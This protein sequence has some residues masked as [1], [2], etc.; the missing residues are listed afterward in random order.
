[1]GTCPSGKWGDCPNAVPG[2][3]EGGYHTMVCILTRE[4]PDNCE[5]ASPKHA[6]TRAEPEFP[7]DPN[8][9]DF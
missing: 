2:M 7:D 3:S 4:H 6:S 9:R 1:M 8:C 5:N